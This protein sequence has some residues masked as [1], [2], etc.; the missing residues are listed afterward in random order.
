VREERRNEK[1]A[2]DFTLRELCSD[3]AKTDFGRFGTEVRVHKRLNSE[4]KDRKMAKHEYLPSKQSLLKNLRVRETIDKQLIQEV[5]T[6][7]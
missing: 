7:Q 3:M 6:L 4:N 5:E 2:S 1:T